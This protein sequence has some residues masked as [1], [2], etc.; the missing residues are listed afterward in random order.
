MTQTLISNWNQVVT[1]QDIVYHVG[2]F[3]MGNRD[4]LLDIVPKLNGTIKLIIGNHD[5]TYKG[6]LYP[7]FDQLNIEH[8]ESLYLTVDK[9]KLFLRHIPDMEF[10]PNDLAEYH[11]CGHVHQSFTKVGNIL[12]AGVDVNEY[13]PKTIQQLI[14][15]PEIKGK[16]HRDSKSMGY[17]HV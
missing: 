10:V 8:F 1:N 17:N 12:N 7:H 16:E 14:D 6:K 4:A 3:A 2:D 5:R 15:M 11:V 13:K 9:Y